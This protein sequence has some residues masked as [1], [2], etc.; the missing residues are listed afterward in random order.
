MTTQ[1]IKSEIQDLLDKIPESILEDILSYLKEVETKSE[2][3]ITAS[4]NISKILHEEKELLEKL[5]Q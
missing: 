3:Q 1:E 2:D 5:A 4:R